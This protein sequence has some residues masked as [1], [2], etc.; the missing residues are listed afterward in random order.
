MR[1]KKKGKIAMKTGRNLQEVLIELNRQ[2]KPRL[3][4][5]GADCRNVAFINEEQN[6][7]SDE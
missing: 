1:R 4:K 5:C 6:E 2:N 7:C 3:E